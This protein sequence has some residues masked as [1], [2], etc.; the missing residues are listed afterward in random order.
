MPVKI[1]S[2]DAQNG[3]LE[4]ITFADRVRPELSARWPAAID[5]QLPMLMGLSA[6]MAG[7]P[8]RAFVAREG[9]EVVARVAAVLDPEYAQRWG[10]KLGHLLFF[11]A[12]AGADGA[13]RA[14]LDA[15]CE[16]LRG[17]GA[18]AARSGFYLP[19]DMPFVI[20]EYDALPPNM[21]RQN[22]DYYHSMIKDAGFFCEKGMVD[23]KIEVTPDLIARYQ[24]ALE[25]A[26]R[27]G[28]ELK[29]LAEIPQE[30]RA[31]EFGPAFNEAFYNHWGYVVSNQEAMTEMM[32]FVE[33]MG[34]LDTSICAYQRGQV[35]GTLMVVPEET[36][37]AKLLPGR[38]I[39]DS[40]KLNFLGIGVREP[41]R[42]R[43]L[44]IAM[45]AQA[46]LTLIDR[47]AKYLSYTLVV[48]DNWPSR[49]TAEK[50]GAKVCANYVVY[51]R[52]FR[53]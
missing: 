3:L 15:G 18:V 4:F 35:V 34:G 45:A 40:E 27:A 32:I 8:I 38:V 46:Y 37:H 14:V 9:G 47:G 24:S 51:R 50:L 12:A 43:G 13:A 19:L 26:R 20:D 41:A 48:D 16:W 28:F 17:Q 22:P 6:F 29:T 44:N 31:G 36:A 2:P 30:K 1:E 23:Y 7:K 42:G 25:A 11:E 49:R 5:M 10:E 53:A 39:K 21:M 33:L 52:N